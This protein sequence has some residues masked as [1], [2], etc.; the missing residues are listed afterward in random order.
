MMWPLRLRW[1]LRFFRCGATAGKKRIER[2]LLNF[3]HNIS[4]PA[5]YEVEA[6]R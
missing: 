3:E 1:K 6:V 5:D 4:A 2:I